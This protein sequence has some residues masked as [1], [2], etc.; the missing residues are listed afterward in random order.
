MIDWRLHIALQ[1]VYLK[2]LL[3]GFIPVDLRFRWANHKLF[4]GHTF[5]VTGSS[6][7]GDFLASLR[8]FKR[9]LFLI[10]QQSVSGVALDSTSF[11]CHKEKQKEDLIPYLSHVLKKEMRPGLCR[12]T[13]RVH[14]SFSW[15]WT[16]TLGLLLSLPFFFLV[17]MFSRKKS[18]VSLVM[19]QWVE[20]NIALQAFV[21]QGVQRV[22]LFGGYENDQGLTGLM[23]EYAEVQLILVPSSNPIKNFYHEVIAHGFVFTSPFQRKEYADL[24]D[25]WSIKEMLDWPLPVVKKLLPYVKTVPPRSKQIAFMSRGVWLRKLR[26][27]H[28][29]NNNRDFDYEEGCMDVLRSFLN[30][31]KSISLLILPHPMERVNEEY[32]QKTQE[33]YTHYF[34]GIEVYFPADPAVKSFQMFGESELALASVSSVNIERLFCGY[35]TLYA[36]IGA[37]HQFFSGSTLDNIVAR[38]PEK[39]MQL[40]KESMQLNENEFFE[41]YELTEYR[42]SSI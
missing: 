12:D 17:T 33:Y 14:L 1:W 8:Y 37:E 42:Y 27:V 40:L 26:G 20:N 7:E 11:Y 5:R 38:T 31:N 34:S 2:V 19:L 24:K 29:Q 15:K 30:E 32:W 39:L 23:C 21:G 4:E 3:A 22:Y 9:A 28:A 18:T 36:P 6:A 10:W 16:M 41:R 13:M 25:R 35:K